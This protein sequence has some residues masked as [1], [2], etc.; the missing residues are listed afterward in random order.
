MIAFSFVLFYNFISQCYAFLLP[1]ISA[2]GYGRP[3]AGSCGGEAREEPR[4]NPRH[5]QDQQQATDQGWDRVLVPLGQWE[6]SSH[7]VWCSEGAFQAA[8]LD[9]LSKNSK[10]TKQ[11]VI[12]LII[13]EDAMF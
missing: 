7:V 3:R 4:Q 5:H 13:K 9:F 12:I 2:R 6:A 10:I 1:F 8:V 11:L